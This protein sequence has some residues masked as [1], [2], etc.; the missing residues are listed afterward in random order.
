MHFPPYQL[1]NHVYKT[2]A[3]ARHSARVSYLFPYNCRSRMPA[4][5]D[6][7]SVRVRFRLAKKKPPS[8]VSASPADLPHPGQV[9]AYAR[10]QQGLGIWRYLFYTMAVSCHHSN[11]SP[12]VDT[13]G[14]RKLPRHFHLPPPKRRRPLDWIAAASTARSD[15]FPNSFVDC[16]GGPECRAVF[17]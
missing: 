17:P 15:L 12:L 6:S 13:A 5:T 14:K 3:C 16:T 8:S 7:N 9:I 2:R 10:S 11:S 4:S 1:P